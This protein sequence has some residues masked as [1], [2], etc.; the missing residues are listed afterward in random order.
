MLVYLVHGFNVQDDG[1]NT[2]GRLR[3]FFERAGCN[4]IELNYGYFNLLRVRLCNRS[5]ARVIASSIE[6]DSIV[7]GHSNGCAIIYRAAKA[8][9][10]FR[11]ATLINPALDDD[12][13]IAGARTVDVWYS[14]TDKAVPLSRLLLFHTWGTQGRDGYNGPPKKNYRQFNADLE[15]DADVGHSGIFADPTRSRKVVERT[16]ARANGAA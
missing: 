13:A 14:P 15:F 10:K 11:H 6:P 5:I 3:P 9:A 7:V 4:V 2:V 1:A 12:K 16:L 8:G